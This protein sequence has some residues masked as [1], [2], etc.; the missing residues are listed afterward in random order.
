MA[1]PLP[2]SPRL[3][4]VNVNEVMEKMAS[5]RDVYNFLTLECEAYLPKVDTVNIFFLKQITRGA[6]DV[7]THSPHTLV[8]EA[9]SRQGGGGA[10]DRGPHGG[11]LP[12]ARTQEAV[13]TALP[14]GRE[15]LAP[16]RQEVG[17]RC[18]LHA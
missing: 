5:K 6:K 1:Q 18:T 11:G 12:Q 17:V 10:S 15:G 3:A 16:P 9:F 4:Q 8:R 13:A 14:A 2:Q 7:S